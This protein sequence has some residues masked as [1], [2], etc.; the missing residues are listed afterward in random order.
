MESP[1]IANSDESVRSRFVDSLKTMVEEAEHLLKNAQRSGTDE[2]KNARDRFE[3]HLKHAK[4]ELA[5]FEDEAIAK[6]KRAAKA[7]DQAVH[8]HP[9]AAMGIAAG[10]GLLIG[11]L[12]ARR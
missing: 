3:S 5:R 9:Y 2:F 12:V 10:V 1:N 6:A 11:L 4:S 7:T 8:E